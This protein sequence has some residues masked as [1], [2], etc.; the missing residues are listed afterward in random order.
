LKIKLI[1]ENKMFLFIY[2]QSLS[3]IVLSI[4]LLILLWAS[5]NHLLRR[6]VRQINA[7]L[8]C[9]T[10]FAII[11]I[12]LFNRSQTETEIILQPFHSFIEARIQPELYRSMLMNLFLFVPFG[13]TLPYVLPQ[14]MK[15]GIL[16]TILLAA[17]FSAAIEI[18]QYI[19]HLGRCEMDDVLMNT[20][21][22]VLGS[23]G[24][25]IRRWMERDGHR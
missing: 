4:I 11:Y 9:L 17:A 20:A 10:V 2:R 12:T 14:K 3:N 21:G 23:M 22:A 16:L 1:K 6:G 24:W 8:F 7:V 5:F 13:L 15:R 19:F 25:V 18:S